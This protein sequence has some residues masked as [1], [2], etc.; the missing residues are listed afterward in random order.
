MPRLPARTL[1]GHI[2]GFVGARLDDRTDRELLQSFL[3]RREESAFA[4]LL[5]RHAPLVWGVCRRTLEQEQDAEDAFQAAFLLLAQKAA[6][7]RNTETVGGWLHGVACRMAM[8]ARRSRM[9]RQ[10]HEE[11]AAQLGQELTNRPTQGTG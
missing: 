5:Q 7:I 1:L 3:G 6:S 9:R 8:N 2:R 10:Q 11:H 4:S